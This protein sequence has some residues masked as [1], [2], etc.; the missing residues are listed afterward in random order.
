MTL[1]LSLSRTVRF[2]TRRRFVQYQM[3]DVMGP[4]ISISAQ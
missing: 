2:L 3:N 1:Y 4:F